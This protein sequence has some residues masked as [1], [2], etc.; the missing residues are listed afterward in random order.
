MNTDPR[1]SAGNP[2]LASVIQPD[3]GEL[4]APGIPLDFG[5]DQLAPEAAPKLGAHTEEVLSGVLGM[6]SVEIGLLYDKG[7]L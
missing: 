7:V 4:L 3:I 2:L 6:N 5:A 1:A